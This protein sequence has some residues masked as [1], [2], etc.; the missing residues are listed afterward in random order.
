MAQVKLDAPAGVPKPMKRDKALFLIKFLGAVIVLY[1]IIALNP[2]NDRVIVPFTQ[3]ITEVSAGLLRALGQQADVDGTLIR[4]ERFTVDVKNGC[5]GIEAI[6][7]LVAAIGAFPAPPLMRVGGI[8]AGAV[9]LQLIN[10]IRIAS[11]VWLGA[12]HPSVFQ[13]FHVAI[14]QTLIILVSLV[15]FLIWSWKFAP[16]KRLATSP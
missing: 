12:H 7:L 11:L 15:L 14:W 8:V 10:V 3:R 5:N 4:T 16:L 2:V 6:I 13:M 9:L 1:V